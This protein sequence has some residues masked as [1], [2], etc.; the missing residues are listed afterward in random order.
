[1]PRTI[2]LICSLSRQ[3]TFDEFDTDLALGCS[4]PNEN[5]PYP[6]RSC[7]THALAHSVIAVCV[8]AC[9]KT[10][11]SSHWHLEAMNH[12]NSQEGTFRGTLALFVYDSVVCIRSSLAQIISNLKG[13]TK[14]FPWLMQRS[15]CSGSIS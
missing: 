3:L 11:S 5:S 14:T 7:V 1:M 6:T 9:H 13:I 2:M 15:Q 4:S 10:V 8:N 12:H